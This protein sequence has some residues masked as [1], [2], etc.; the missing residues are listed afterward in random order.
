MVTINELGAP[1]PSLLTEELERQPVD[2]AG[3]TPDFASY[4]R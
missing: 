4:L 3:V 1:S 2:S